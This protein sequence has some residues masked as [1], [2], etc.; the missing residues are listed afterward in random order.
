M[1]RILD[2]IIN[3]MCDLKIISKTD[4]ALY[5]Y[6][7]KNGLIKISISIFYLLLISK[8]KILG[9]G[10][11]FFI[12]FKLL[13]Q[14]AGGYHADSRLGCYIQT[15]LILALGAINLKLHIIPDMIVSMLVVIA[16]ILIFTYDPIT[17]ENRKLDNKQIQVFKKVTRILAIIYI[18]LLIVCSLLGYQEIAYAVKCS[19]ITTEFFVILGKLKEKLRAGYNILGSRAV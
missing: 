2:A 5:L 8:L 12:I 10:L 19:V 16:I 17:G 1:S 9:S 4:S 7:L 13:R 6:G 15:N 11:F 18:M 14:Y 3:R